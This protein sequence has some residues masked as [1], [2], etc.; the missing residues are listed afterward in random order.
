[1][2]AKKIHNEARC[3]IALCVI[4][5]ISLI[6]WCGGYFFNHL[7]DLAP[8][9]NWLSNWYNFASPIIAIANVVAFIGL[10]IAIYIGESDRQKKHE[11]IN[12][13][14]TI[15]SKIQQIE[16]ELSE[17]EIGLRKGS[18]E[19]QQLYT[20]YI[21]LYKIE[22]YLKD[23]PKIS[24]LQ[25]RKALKENAEKI[26]QQTTQARDMFI[27]QYQKLKSTGRVFVDSSECVEMSKKLNLVI[28]YLEEFEMSIIQDISLNI[29]T[30]PI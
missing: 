14:N 5:C 15:I 17:G 2:K 9:Y 8:E 4:V 3:A 7:S 16:K 1:M 6:V 10:T 23:L 27:C 20:I 13:Q 11:Q 18:V 12:I 22:N 19:I 30:D 21:S 24:L 28:A 26:E 25:T 29:I